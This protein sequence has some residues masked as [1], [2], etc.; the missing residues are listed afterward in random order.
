M[1]LEESARRAGG[2][3][4]IESRLFE[5]LGSWVPTT[6]DP[7]VK[8]MFDA[9]SRHHAWRA[10]QWTDRLP[11]LSGVDRD[12]LTVPPSP[13]VEAAMG[14]LHALSG[15]PARLAGAYRFALPRLWSRYE[16]HLHASDP[17]SDSSARRTLR[18]VMED[19]AS[20]WRQGESLLQSLLIDSD[21]VEAS[22]SVVVSL[23]RLVA[24]A[25]RCF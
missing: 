10:S 22:A 5:T 18:I 7:D 20:D 19:V 6:P 14:Q 4:W 2:N 16:R 1:S 8:L 24:G 15:S 23:E 21:A 9:H 3:R 12:E 25:D 13:Q 11:R 17:V